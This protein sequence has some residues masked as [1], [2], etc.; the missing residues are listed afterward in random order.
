MSESTCGARLHS[1]WNY[2]YMYM[3]MYIMATSLTYSFVDAVSEHG[4][5]G[6]IVLQHN[7]LEY[8]VQAGLHA[9]IMINT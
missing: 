8:V 6:F 1:T 7:S 9:T 4:F 2:R 3:Y 5:Y